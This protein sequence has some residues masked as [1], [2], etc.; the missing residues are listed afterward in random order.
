MRLDEVRPRH[1]KRGADYGM[2]AADLWIQENLRQG[3]LF[4]GINVVFP[5]FGG[6]R[7]A[8]SL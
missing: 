3:L 2:P 6:D 1:D 5:S 8:A 4:F 7:N